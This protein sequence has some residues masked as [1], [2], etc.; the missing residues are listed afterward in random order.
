MDGREI[1]KKKTGKGRGISFAKL[2]F[3]GMEGK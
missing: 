3:N 2:S 1:D